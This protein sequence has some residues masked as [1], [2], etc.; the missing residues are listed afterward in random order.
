MALEYSREYRTY[1]HTS[2]HD[3]VSESSAYKT[4]KW[5]E[6]PKFPN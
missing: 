4:I 6:D 2:Q 3:G 5:I 1:F